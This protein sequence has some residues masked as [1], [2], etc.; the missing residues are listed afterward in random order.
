M[1]ALFQNDSIRGMLFFLS[2]AVMLLSSLLCFVFTDTKD[3]VLEDTL[4]NYD[5]KHGVS[6]TP[7]MV[8][9]HKT[10]N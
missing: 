8:V 1:F 7:V 5:D 9:G 6:D 10:R 3:Q 2:G 4:K